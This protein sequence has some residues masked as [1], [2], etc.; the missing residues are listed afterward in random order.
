MR[1]KP[2]PDEVRQLALEIFRD[3]GVRRPAPA[4][5]V[6]TILVH[7]GRYRGRS[8]RLGRLMAMWMFDVGLL[9]FYGADGSMLLTIDLIDRPASTAKAA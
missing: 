6:E 4:D 8:Y 9:Q 3:L 2:T 1:A 7:D 5:L